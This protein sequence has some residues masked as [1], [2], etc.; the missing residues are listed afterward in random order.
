MRR[1]VTD[2][3]ELTLGQVLDFVRESWVSVG[4]SLVLGVAVALTVFATS[5]RVYR[6][7]TVVSAS[8][9]SVSGGMIASLAGQL[10]MFGGLASDLG[11]SSGDDSRTV[12]LA[13]LRS[14]ELLK[15]YML[16]NAVM[17]E[18]FADKW[19]SS[20]ATWRADIDQTDTP[21]INEGIDK[22]QRSVLRISED[23]RTGLITLSVDWRDPAI[24]AKWANGLVVL[25]NARLQQK[26]I[27]ENERSIAYL[28]EQLKLT[29]VVER[30][31]IIHRLIE[32]RVS[33]IMLAKGRPDYAFA[34]IDPAVTPD[35]K[36]FVKP[37]LIFFVLSG[38]FGGVLF[39]LLAA[40]V[41]RSRSFSTVN[42]RLSENS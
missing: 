29:A 42:G 39:G 14:R 33:E 17:A 32:S 3:A 8:A 11:L 19:D 15:E 26:A 7:E 10:G 18:L 12:F 41:Q 21:T 40:T 35:T 6:A 22:F 38:L 31:R 28:E 30:E 24:A 27:Q 25:V 4:V 36:K 34:V 13:S 5:D 20:R 23:K 1:I 9:S 37:N 16:S 2:S